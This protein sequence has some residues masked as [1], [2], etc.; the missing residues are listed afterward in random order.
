MSAMRCPPLPGKAPMAVCRLSTCTRF[1]PLT[2]AR[3]PGAEL[4]WLLP[5]GWIHD[6]G[7]GALCPEHAGV[8][9]SVRK[10]RA[11]LNTTGDACH[12]CGSV[13]LEPAGSCLRCLDCGTGTG[14]G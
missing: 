3:G 14:C 9:V 2:I 6:V 11:R 13:N 12:E 1:T 4:G 8:G 5:P 10:E 7:K